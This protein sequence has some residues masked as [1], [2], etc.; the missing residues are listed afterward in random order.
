MYVMQYS[1]PPPLVHAAP[2]GVQFSV[3]VVP[4]LPPLLLV[5]PLLP[6][7][8]VP[9]LPLLLLLLLVPELP[10]L[11]LLVPELPPLLLVP[12]LPLLLLA[13]ELPLPLSGVVSSAGGAGS[14]VPSPVAEGSAPGP[15]TVSVDV[16]LEHAAREAAATRTGRKRKEGE[17]FMPGSYGPSP[18]TSPRAP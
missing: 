11:L 13:P 10:P 12:E 6:L 5:L 3:V 16:P 14:F 2:I 1:M 4:E 17:I 8:L 9:E 15:G 7:L 18:Q